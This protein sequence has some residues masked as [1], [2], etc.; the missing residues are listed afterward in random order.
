ME[1][2]ALVHNSSLPTKIILTISSN[3]PEVQSER[4]WSDGSIGAVTDF[5]IGVPGGWI[6][7]DAEDSASCGRA[8]TGNSRWVAIESYN[9]GV[10]CCYA[11]GRDCYH[12]FAGT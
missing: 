2:L 12:C 3:H 10:G 9:D 7:I 8:I 6:R 1:A 5:E 11:A 4:T